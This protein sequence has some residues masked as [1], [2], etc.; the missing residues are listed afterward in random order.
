MAAS[1]AIHPTKQ[2]LRGPR[3]S[4]GGPSER[5]WRDSTTYHG[6]GNPPYIIFGSGKQLPYKDCAK[7]DVGNGACDIPRADVGIRPYV[8][9][10]TSNVR[11]YGIV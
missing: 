5:W 6:Y 1:L 3:L 2:V 4:V 8:I 9:T 10:R 7:G 11:P